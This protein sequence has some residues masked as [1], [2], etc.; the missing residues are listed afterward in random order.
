MTILV[1]KD[2]KS[3]KQQNKLK[4]YSLRHSFFPDIIE[5]KLHHNAVECPLALSRGQ[6][7]SQVVSFKT[8]SFLS[9]Q[10]WG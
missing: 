9:R 2:T 5:S 1:T 7:D 4:V 8:R 6:R 3:R 10:G